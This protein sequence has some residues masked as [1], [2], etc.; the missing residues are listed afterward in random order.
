VNSKYFLR[1]KISKHA[2]KVAQLL[3]WLE[4]KVLLDMNTAQDIRSTMCAGRKHSWPISGVASDC[5]ELLV[6]QL[7]IMR[8]YHA[9]I[10]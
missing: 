4:T 6:P 1:L 10:N 7:I 9:A 5:L 2:V 3:Q 8:H